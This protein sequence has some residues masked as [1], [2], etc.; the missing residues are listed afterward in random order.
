[1]SEVIVIS[2]LCALIIVRE[3]I[4]LKTIKQLTDKIMAKNYQEYTYSNNPPKENSIAQ[5]PV[6]NWN[7]AEDLGFLTGLQ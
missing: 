4:F 5:T 2:I 3:I 7:E 6:V 1:L